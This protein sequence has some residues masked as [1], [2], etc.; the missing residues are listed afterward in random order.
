M[1]QYLR[2]THFYGKKFLSLLLY[3]ISFLDVKCLPLFSN[4]EFLNIKDDPEVSQQI[5]F[6]TYLLLFI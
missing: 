6:S 3:N 5:V 4:I 2:D 1:L